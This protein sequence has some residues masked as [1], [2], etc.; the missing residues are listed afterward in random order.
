M[1]VEPHDHH[2]KGSADGP[3]LGGACSH[4]SSAWKRPR[5]VVTNPG[6]YRLLAGKHFSDTLQQYKQA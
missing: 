2:K 6:Y 1:E 4:N 3:D 5:R